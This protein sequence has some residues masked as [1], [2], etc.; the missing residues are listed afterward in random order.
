[1]EL[2]TEDQLPPKKDWKGNKKAVFSTLGS[3]NHSDLEREKHDFYATDP[4]A[5]KLLLKYESFKNVWECA[6]GQG[7]LSEV[8]KTNQIHGK[9]SDMINRGY[10]EIEDFLMIDNI[11]W[12]GIL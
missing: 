8:L 5:L 2:F 7:H 1:M 3:S 9:S 12:G 11:K 4:K 6:C 10:G